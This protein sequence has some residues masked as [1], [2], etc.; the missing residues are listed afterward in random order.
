MKTRYWILILAA[1]ALLCSLVSLPL[2]LPREDAA[3]AEIISEG[4]TVT[5]VDL[6][7]DQSFSVM[8]PIGS[9]TI[10]VQDGK[11]GVTQASCP[12]H[13]CMSRGMCSQGAQIVCLPN[14]LIIR[15]VGAQAVDSVAG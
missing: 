2:I 6:S 3:Y 7:A 1:I 13:D 8:T 12:D 15:F 9:N 14:H 5:I 11:I 10:T 4:R